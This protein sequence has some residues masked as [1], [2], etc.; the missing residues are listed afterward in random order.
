MEE[1]NKEDARFFNLALL[2]KKK[3]SISPY[4]WLGNNQQSHLGMIFL[5]KAEAYHWPELRN[6]STASR[7]F[8][9]VKKL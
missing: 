8:L 3:N 9:L 2:L 7:G 1:K 4:Q 6:L 5:S